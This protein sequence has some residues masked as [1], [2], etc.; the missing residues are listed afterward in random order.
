MPDNFISLPPEF[1]KRVLHEYGSR[2]EHI[3]KAY[4]NEAV[5]SIRLNSRKIKGRLSSSDILTNFGLET[6]TSVNMETGVPVP[7]AKDAFYLTLRPSYA[8]DPLFHAGVYY[9]QEASSMILELIYKALYTKQD[10]IKVL[11]LCAA[12]GGKSTHL[13]SLLSKKSVL[14]ANEIVPQRFQILRENLTKWGHPNVLLS[15]LSPSRLEVLGET[16]DLI[17]VDAPCS[18]E[19]LFRKQPE[20]TSGWS[21][22]NC[23]HC[24]HRQDKILQSAVRLL[25]AGGHLIYSTC[26]LNKAENLDQLVKLSQLNNMISLPITEME[27]FEVDEISSGECH[28]YQ[29]L[30]DRIQGE[31]FFIAVMQKQGFSISDSKR[32]HRGRRTVGSNKYKLPWFPKDQACI[33]RDNRLYFHN[34]LQE[35]L[36]QKMYRL[37]VNCQSIPSALEKGRDI[38]PTHFAA[39]RY[40]IDHRRI[41][42][43][44][45]QALAFLRCSDFPLD[46]DSKGWLLIDYSSIPL[47]WIKYDGRRI[48]SKYP[49]KW[50]LRS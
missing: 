27:N 14:L 4:Q 10:E 20:W 44:L 47:G 7:W 48:N 2:G 38:I 49:I 35:G 6:N 24:A 13:L 36:M 21:L 37:K 39:M 18:G 3:L 32:E 41:S 23:D 28:A 45:E 1:Q 40:D 5:T 17:L 31:A 43:D 46:M 15:N 11:D 30:P 9:P 33:S 19:G 29:L 34:E 26:T 42:L 12:P 25:K 16:F 22:T 8:L 50:R